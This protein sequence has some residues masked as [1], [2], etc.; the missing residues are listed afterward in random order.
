MVAAYSCTCEVS[1]HACSPLCLQQFTLEPARLLLMQTLGRL[2]GLETTVHLVHV[3]MEVSATDLRA[4]AH[5]CLVGKD[6]CVK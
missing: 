5:A 3:E 6:L 4:V 2:V 1:G